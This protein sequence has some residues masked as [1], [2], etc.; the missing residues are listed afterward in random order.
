MTQWIRLDIEAGVGVIRLDRPPVNALCEAA[1]DQ[2]AD[3]ARTAATRTAVRAVVVHG[4]DRVFSGGGD[5]RELHLMGPAEGAALAVKTFETVNL[6]AE[7]DKPVIAA[8]NGYA[9]G[10]G[11]ELALGCDLRVV[12]EDCRLGLPET[13]IGIIP[14]AGGTQRLARLVGLGRAKRMVLTAALVDADEALAIGMVDWVVPSEQVL[15]KAM[16]I[17]TALANGPTQALAAA[18]RA[19]DHAFDLPLG[20][21]LLRE[22]REFARVLAT[23]DKQEG[24]AA[25]LDKRP[26]RFTGE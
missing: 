4:G 11:F 15:A 5:I 14:G 21:G 18:K 3:A 9:C 13:S 22:S 25:F 8:I 16:E 6:L 23:K 7:M 20:D 17:A 1:I 10:G 19:L 26:P 2:L 24:I 12:A